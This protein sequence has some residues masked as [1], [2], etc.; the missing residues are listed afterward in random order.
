MANAIDQRYAQALADLVAKGAIAADLA[1]RELGEMAELVTGS[2]PL[3]AVMASPAVSWDKKLQLLDAVAAKA[4]V[5]RISRNFLAVSAQRGRFGHLPGM[6]QAFEEIM[7]QQQGVVRAEV[8]SARPLGEAE[9]AGIERQ[10]ETRLG[11]KLQTRYRTDPELVGGFIARVG[12]QVYDGSI[13]GR[14]HRLR[15]ALV[16]A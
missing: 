10:L 14:L 9:R 16:S 2:A 7:L 6:E 11:R 1:R 12:D 4:G 15:H 5:S 3:R 13:R 8:T